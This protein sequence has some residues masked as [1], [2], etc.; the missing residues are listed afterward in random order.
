MLTACLLIKYKVTHRRK[1][2]NKL[3][4][5]K[6][7]VKNCKGLLYTFHTQETREQNQEVQMKVAIG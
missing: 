3:G 5:K 4:D 6:K 7:G 2:L 1:G